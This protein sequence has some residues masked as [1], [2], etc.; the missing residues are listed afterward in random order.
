[1]NTQEKKGP[2]VG[3][4][5]TSS[6]GSDCYAWEVIA[7]S[8]DGLS[9]TIREM[10]Y[11]SIGENYG[12]E[13]Y[14]YFPNPEGGTRDLTYNEKHGWGIEFETIE[15]IKALAKRLQ[16]EFGYGWTDYL[17]DGYTY[18]DLIDG[19]SDQ[20]MPRLKLIENITK[21]Y[22]NFSPMNISFGHARRYQDPHF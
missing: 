1:M 17:P 22:K 11:K 21:K 19:D 18:K 9:C 4:G 7:V 16:K 13:R 12:D 5:A 10:G 2:E 3:K 8:E 6:V 20:P 15:I 14:E